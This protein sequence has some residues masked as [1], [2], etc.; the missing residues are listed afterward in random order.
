VHD[1]RPIAADLSLDRERFELVEQHSAVRDFYDKEE[2]RQSR[3]RTPRRAIHRRVAHHH[4]RPHDPPASLGRRGSR[5]GIATPA[6]NARAQ[7][8]YRVVGAQRIRDLKDEQ[9]DALLG[10][11]YEFINVWR[12]IRGP[13]RDAPLAMCNARTVSAGDLIPSDLIYRDR[14]GEI[15]LMQHNPKAVL[16]LRPGDARRRSV[17]VEML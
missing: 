15:Y 17:A 3:S 7:R 12:P 1:A 13:L 11:R 5:C 9:A 2:L 4:L 6:S 8:L 10:H 16:V 14:K